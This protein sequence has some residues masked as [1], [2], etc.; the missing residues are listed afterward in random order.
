[1]R[2][3]FNHWF[4]AIDNVID[5]LKEKF[6]LYMIGSNTNQYAV[7]KHS[8]DE[9]YQEPE[10]HDGDAYCSYALDFCKTH[11]IDVL[12]P[13][14]FLLAIAEHLD[15]FTNIGVKV[16]CSTNYDVLKILFD[17]CA[18]Y[19]YINS[20]LPDLIPEYYICKSADEFKNYYEI[21]STKY[22]RICYKLVHDEGASSFRIIEELDYSEHAIYH[23]LGNKIPFEFAIKIIENYS[24]KYNIIIMPYLQGPEVSVDCLNTNT[25]KIIIPRFKTDYRYS[26]IDEL[27]KIL[28]LDL[29]GYIKIAIS[30]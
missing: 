21:L 9:W 20:Y 1:M 8:C 5:L 3:W 25:G 16:L 18:T 30:I 28:D 24:F 26:I 15:L 17:K 6:S 29:D 7:Y 14:R 19:D 10:C 2:I 27:F 12:I 13:R 4:S 23:K 11:N 22:D